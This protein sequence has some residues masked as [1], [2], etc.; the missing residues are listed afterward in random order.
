MGAALRPRFAALLLAL[1][2]AVPT[3][4]VETTG[5]FPHPDGFLGDHGVAAM[6][7]G[8]SCSACHGVAVTDPVQ[9]ATPAAPACQSCHADFPH[10]SDFGT[11]AAHGEAWGADSSACTSCH[12]DAGDRAPAGLSR[13]QCT[14]CHASYPHATGWAEAAGHGAAVLDRA[15]A[16]A[17]SAC[18]S[19]E[20][21]ADPGACVTCH[22]SYPH[23]EGWAQAAGHGAAVTGGASCAVGCHP[24][25]PATASPRLACASCHDLFP[26]APGWPTGHI[27]LV[28][29]RGEGAC[30]S[31]HEAGTPSGGTMPV[32]C[33]ASCHAEAE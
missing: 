33:G 4:R 13:G 8:A 14:S 16:H 24:S 11:S 15:G 7:G 2:C 31:C 19:G 25:D 5:G 12:G 26:H 21:S 27:A 6:A 9:G 22:A 29:A 20:D 18:H 28:Q 23:P 1:G 10:A 32:S 17:C 30:Q 3:G